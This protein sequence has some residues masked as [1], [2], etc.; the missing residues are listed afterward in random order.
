MSL[1]FLLL[2]ACFFLLCTLLGLPFLLLALLLPTCFFLLC[3]Q[4]F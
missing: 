3:T 1:P 4:G 2:S